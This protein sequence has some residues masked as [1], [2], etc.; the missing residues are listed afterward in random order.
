ML[1]ITL[2]ICF[3]SDILR[4]IALPVQSKLFYNSIC[5][6]SIFMLPYPPFYLKVVCLDMIRMLIFHTL[7]YSIKIVQR[8]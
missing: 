3:L 6:S 5:L 1:L 8:C 7:N 2:Q 4:L